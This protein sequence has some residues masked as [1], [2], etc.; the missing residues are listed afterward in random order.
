MKPIINTAGNRKI[1]LMTDEYFKIWALVLPISSFVLFPDIKGSTPAY[2]FAIMSFFF[3]C[4]FVRKRS[5][6][7]KE[8]FLYLFGFIVLTLFA[9]MSL[10]LS[11]EFGLNNFANLRLVSKNESTL[12]FRT[13]L[14]TQSIY[15]FVGILT[16]VYVKKFYNEKWDN[17]IFAGIT[18]LALYGIYEFL[19]FLI[20]RKNGDFISNRIFGDSKVFNGSLFQL[21]HVGPFIF[22]RLKSLTGE[23]SMYSFTVLPFW[24]YA[25]HKKKTFLHLFL[26][27]TLIMST[28]TTAI[29]GIVIYLI[30]RLIFLKFRDRY[31]LGFL[32]FGGAIAF[33][34]ANL[35]Q[36]LYKKSLIE[37]LTLQT[38]SGTERF[39][40]FIASIDCF[41]ELS[42]ANKLFGI[43][44][45]YI[46]STD[47]FSTLLVNN[48]II[49]LILFSC[50]FFYAV[51]KLGNSYYE[52]GLKLAL[53]VIYFSMMISVSEYSYL[54][55][56][57][58][59]GMSYNVVL[60][61]K[62]CNPPKSSSY[63]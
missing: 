33:F 15:L 63:T 23:P 54:S 30:F 61:K 38:T 2:I 24:V 28:S 47:M 55:I 32:F 5:D 26:L 22:Q 6:Y 45:G 48:G 35:M 9:Q 46:R 31:S 16:F 44:F 3:V 8:N 51:Y 49:G 34:N 14:Y 39:N 17:A 62:Y 50:L 37:K 53:L 56:W 18:I 19:Y 59:L 1:N 10:F 36:E 60:S 12:Y 40:S 27:A 29:A 13:S 42:F 25:V 20:F 52:I 4:I 58:F 11:D 7:I 41:K 43:G 21:I 57:L